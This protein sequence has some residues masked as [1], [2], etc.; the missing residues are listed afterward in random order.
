LELRALRRS[1][2]TK[3]MYL[4]PQNRDNYLT[5]EGYEYLAL[6]RRGD[7]LGTLMRHVALHPGIFW[8]HLFLAAAYIELGRDD[9]A[10]AEA[11]EVLQ[12]N[13]EFSL[14]MVVR[15]VGPKGKWLAADIRLSADL[16]KAG[17]Q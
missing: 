1:T 5:V 12:L 13:P 4:D 9:A 15:T 17:L 14:T 16:R 7:A 6:G 3:A 8:D 11:P 2:S 10:R